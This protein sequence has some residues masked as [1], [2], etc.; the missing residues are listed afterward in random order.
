MEKST[1]DKLPIRIS[2][3]TIR[4]STRAR[5]SSRFVFAVQVLRFGYYDTSSDRNDGVVLL[6]LAWP[7]NPYYTT[8]LSCSKKK[9]EKKGRQKNIPR[10]MGWGTSGHIFV[11][12]FCRK[13]NPVVISRYNSSFL[14]IVYHTLIRTKLEYTS[15]ISK[16]PISCLVDMLEYVRNRAICFIHRSFAARTL[17][18]LRDQLS[19]PPL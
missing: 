10:T 9:Q 2:A 3:C 17:T 11:T 6:A 19:L 4:Q 12:I 18:L 5:P 13:Q 16:P 7:T 8:V 14:C 15:E 1:N